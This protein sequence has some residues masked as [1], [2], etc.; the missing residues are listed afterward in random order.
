MHTALVNDV[1]VRVRI[2]LLEDITAWDVEDYRSR[3]GYV[4]V[5]VEVAGHECAV[6][7]D[8]DMLEAVGR[9][10]DNLVIAAAQTRIQELLLLVQFEDRVLGSPVCAGRLEVEIKCG[11]AVAGIKFAPCERL[12]LLRLL[13]Q[14]FADHGMASDALRQISTFFTLE[15]EDLTC[16]LD[17][18]VKNPLLGVSPEWGSSTLAIDRAGDTGRSLRMSLLLGIFIIFFQEFSYLAS[19][20]NYM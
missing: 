8:V 15:V 7:G 19:L 6:P 4:G 12:D 3:A 16:L 13:S 18:V 9:Q 20:N 14:I 5:D 17:E 2:Y 11:L 10:R 1:E